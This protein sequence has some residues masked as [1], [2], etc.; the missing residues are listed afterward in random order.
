MQVFKGSLDLA[1]ANAD[2]WVSDFYEDLMIIVL[3]GLFE[4]IKNRFHGVARAGINL[5]MNP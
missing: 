5:G 1:L 2:N 4:Y 3:R